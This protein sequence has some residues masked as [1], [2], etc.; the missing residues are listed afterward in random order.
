[1]NI[2]GPCVALNPPRKQ[3]VGDVPHLHLREHRTPRAYTPLSTASSASTTAPLRHF[4]RFTSE[5]R[6][7]YFTLLTETS[8]IR[9]PLRVIRRL[10]AGFR[11]PARRDQ[12]NRRLQLRVDVC[13]ALARPP[14]IITDRAFPS[15]PFKH[16]TSN[17]NYPCYLYDPYKII[18]VYTC[19]P[20]R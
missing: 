10:R 17:V 7:V 1:M 9:V 14:Y 4:A 16:I 11:L 8:L 13:V 19:A 3:C 5:S 2:P 15:K 20:Y 6:C 18:R 12:F